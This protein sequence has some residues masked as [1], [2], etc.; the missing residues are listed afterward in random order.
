MAMRAWRTARRS[1]CSTSGPASPTASRTCTTPG[2]PASP[3]V[4]L[5]GDHATWHLPHDAP[6]SSDIVSLA[7]PVSAWVRTSRCSKELAGDFAEAISAA[8]RPPGQVATLIAPADCQWDPADGPARPRPRARPSLAPMPRSVEATARRLR[9]SASPALLLGLGALREAGLRAA[10]R[11]A[12]ATGAALLCEVFPTRIE[13]GAGRPRLEKLPYFP[14]QAQQRLAGCDVARARGR[15][16]SGLV[17]RIS[18]CR[19]PPRP[20]R[21][22]DRARHARRGRRRR[23]R[24]PRRCARSA[25]ASPGPRRASAPGHSERRAHPGGARRRARAAPARGRDR[26]RRGRDQR[27]GRTFWRPRRP[28]H[29]PIWPS[30]AARSA[31]GCPARR[32]PPSPA[33]SER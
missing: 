28:R 4:N 9:R 15:T 21:R 10:A 5:I 16:G 18:G 14:E 25:R 7:S 12:A 6:L 19:E 8:W 26:G 32:A 30:P 31:R 27:A 22:G 11:I 17:L 24:R 23:P 3:V 29:T 20:R 2:A 33:R 13:R 1:R